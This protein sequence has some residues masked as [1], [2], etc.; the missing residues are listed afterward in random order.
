MNYDTYLNLGRDNYIHNKYSEA[1]ECFQNAYE[2]NKTNE[3]LNYIG[4]C[5]IKLD[6][7]KK[8]YNI[9]DDLTKRTEWER[10][11]FNLGRLY[12]RSEKYEQALKCFNRA[13]EISPSNGDCYFYL[14]VYYESVDNA[15]KA[16]EAYNQA[17]ALAVNPMD[18][19]D[20]HLNLGVIYKKQK[21]YRDALAEFSVA[22]ELDGSCLEALYNAAIVF[23][24]GRKY[25]QALDLFKEVYSR[26]MDDNVTK[27]YI[28]YC[29]TQIE[30]SSKTE[31]E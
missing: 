7:F 4:C 17:I 3:V 10:P 25:Q 11:W 1:L 26:G 21:K 5:Y 29:M 27:E 6:D 14:G 16:I 23:K 9:F 20:V 8:A 13:V 30:G 31:N 15:A 2:I 19:S 28:N 22:Y 12:L 18:I 24:I